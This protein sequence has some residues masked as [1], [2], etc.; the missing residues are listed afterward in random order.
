MPDISGIEVIKKIIDFDPNANDYTSTAWKDE[1]NCDINQVAVW[2]LSAGG[3]ECYIA[4]GNVES[5]TEDEAMACR[6]IIKGSAL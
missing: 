3:F 6:S 5:V 4:G 1:E 2:T